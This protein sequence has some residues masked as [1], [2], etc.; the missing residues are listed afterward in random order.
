MSVFST[1]PPNFS[2]EEA[3]AMVFEL[4]GLTT[5]VSLLN[6]DRDQNFLCIIPDKQKFVLK[7]SN[8]AEHRTILEMQNEC[9]KH[10]LDNPTPLQVPCVIAGTEHDEITE[11]DLESTTYLVRVVHYLPGLLLNDVSHHKSILHELGSFLGNLSLIMS[12]FNHSAAHRNF[13][14]DIAQ[15]DF[16]ETHKHY[17]SE[18]EEI[19]DHFVKL[20]KKNV[21]ISDASLRKAVIHNDCNDHNI[22]VNNNGDMI[23]IIDFGDMVYSFV[24]CE[25]AICMAYVALEKDE[26]LESIAQVLKGFHETFPLTE[27]ELLSMIYFIC[28]RSCI[29]VTMAAYRKL[30]FPENKYIWV[31]EDQSWNFLKQMQNEDLDKWSQKLLSYAQS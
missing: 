28:I 13:P 19:I 20:Y 11:F 6:S 16:I 12:S 15:T 8:P 1:P 9:M 25:P 26:P 22:L 31:T 27:N 14:W 10:I 18:H 24:A 5:N 2:A 30:L 17:V 21:L 7:I 23:G 3:E 4:Y 29:T